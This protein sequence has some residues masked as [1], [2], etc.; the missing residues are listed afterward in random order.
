MSLIEQV[1]QAGVVGAGGG[2]FPTHVKLGAKVEF[3][4]ANGAECEPLMHKDA[5]LMASHAAQVVA[6][7]EAVVAACGAARGIIGIKA[8]HTEAVEAFERVLPGSRVELHLL[9][10]FYPT[11]DEFVL[12][13]ETIGR[14]IPPGGLPHQVGAIVQNVETLF[15]IAAA[16]QGV[17]VTRKFL[18]VAGA[19]RQPFSGAVPVGISFREA[20][21]LAGGT[22]EGEVALL[23]GGAMMG[24]LTRNLDE[25]VEKTTGG[26]IVLPGDHS[27]VQRKERPETSMHRIGKSSCDQCSY[28]TELCP[29]YLLGYHV[30][31]HKVMRS[32]GF[33][34]SGEDFW[35]QM[36]LLCCEC[37]LCTLYACPEDLYPREACQQSK[38]Q[39]RLKGLL[40]QARAAVTADTPKP[41]PLHESRR[42]PLKQLVRRLGLTDYDAPA[43]MRQ[44][45]LAPR[46][47]RLALK[48]HAG[49]PAEPV[50]Q[51]GE[52]V[53]AGQ[54]VAQMPEGQLGAAIHASISGRVRALTP[55]LEIEAG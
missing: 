13:H 14:L 22:S 51:V 16:S 34:L 33:S 44:L 29:R 28:C 35:N 20:I 24:R 31:P 9:E 26:L 3:V 21:E 23:V 43:P 6:G 30:E 4:I 42:I 8:K 38:R 10:D 7:M 50:V 2:G 49:A 39:I 27:L 41:H 19:V 48:Q 25:C 40:D 11:G 37:S 53:Q 45:D 46:R 55:R 12:V 36:G 52:Q 54:L 15:N 32:L 47:V 17:P 18:T 5:E 1:R